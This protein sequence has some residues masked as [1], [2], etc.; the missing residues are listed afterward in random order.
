M[1]IEYTKD[2]KVREELMGLCVDL[3]RIPN[4]Q[5]RIASGDTV[6]NY[7]KKRLLTI[8]PLRN[9]FSVMEENG[10][11]TKGW[12]KESMVKKVNELIDASGR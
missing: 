9:T 10:I 11:T 1:Q 7:N 12:R 3:T 8:V 4:L 2:Q 6:V 5:L